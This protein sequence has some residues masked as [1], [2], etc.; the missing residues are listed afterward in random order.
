LT[1]T[2][3]ADIPAAA[4]PLSPAVT[5]VTRPARRLSNG[6]EPGSVAPGSGSETVRFGPGV[7]QVIA[8]AS[9][10]AGSVAVA[11]ASLVKRRVRG[12]A[13]FLLTAGLTAVLWWWLHRTEPLELSAVTPVGADGVL[14]CNES[15]H[16]QVTVRTNGEA[17]TIEY[18]WLRSDGTQSPVLAETIADGQRSATLVLHWK[19]VGSGTF[20]GQA[21]AVILQPTPLTATAS[22]DYSCP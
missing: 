13:L 15:A 18:R 14:G 9:S 21:N 6:S 8:P 5:G 17:G 10:A 11:R 16:L 2:H 7:P 4:E 12:F 22:F 1:P 3:S 19:V 20:H